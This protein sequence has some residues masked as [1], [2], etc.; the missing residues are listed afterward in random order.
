MLPAPLPSA[1]D[2]YPHPLA[3]VEFCEQELERQVKK[4]TVEGI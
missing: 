3:A 1:N 2:S 4:E